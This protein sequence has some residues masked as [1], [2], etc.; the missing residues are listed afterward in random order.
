MYE[1]FFNEESV[2]WLSLIILNTSM[3]T[4]L[5]FLKPRNTAQYLILATLF[6]LDLFYISLFFQVMSI[7]NYLSDE[8][9]QKVNL[10]F[11]IIGS[12]FLTQFAYRFPEPNKK[13]ELERNI[14]LVFSILLTLLSISLSIKSISNP[15]HDYSD[16]YFIQLLFVLVL[17]LLFVLVLLRRGIRYLLEKNTKNAKS[18]FAF[19]I[20][21][22]FVIGTIGI[23]ILYNLGIIS[24]L[25]ETVADSI[26][27]LG[28]HLL[29]IITYINQ[30]KQPTS[31][32]IKI[33]GI[34]L[35]TVSFVLGNLGHLFLP[36]FK[37]SYKKELTIRSG[38]NISFFRNSKQSYDVSYSNLDWEEDLGEEILP[39]GKEMTSRIKLPFTFPFYQKSLNYFQ[40]YRT[41]LVSFDTNETIYGIR[42]FQYNPSICVVC[43]MSPVLDPQKGKIYLHSTRERVVVTWENLEYNSEL[44][45][46]E[47][48]FLQLT[49]TPNGDINLFYASIPRHQYFPK[50][51]WSTTF[52][53]IGLFPGNKSFDSTFGFLSKIPFSVSEE[54]AISEHFY[55]NAKAYIHE[56]ML[57]LVLTSIAV[58]FFIIL[59]FP[60]MF[61]ASLV[62]PL[63]DLI[64]GIKKIDRGQLD[65]YI[66]P[67]SNDEIGFLTESF[68]KM[69]NSIRIGDEM[70]EEYIEEIQKL[71]NAYQAFFPAEFLLQMSKRSILDIKLGDYK[72]K[73]MTI[74]FSDLR[75]YTTLSEDMSPRENFKFLNSYLKQVSPIIRQ[76]HGF[77]DKYIGDAI[78][79][80][81]PGRVEDA[82]EAA[83]DMQSK[84]K[85]INRARK[86]FHLAPIRAGVGIHTGHVIMGTIGETNR[87]EGTVVSDAV[88]ISSRLE[89][90][91][92]FYSTDI[93]ISMETFIEIEDQ[94]Q[95]FFRILDKVK[96]KGKARHITVIEIMNGLEPI[97]LHNLL[98]TKI[99]F[100]EGIGHYLERTF[101]KAIECFQKVLKV[102]PDDQASKI[103]IQRAEFYLKNGVPVDWNGVEILDHTFVD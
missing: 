100:E 97:K 87:M 56:R 43:F 37:E 71:N 67:R 72:E 33:V 57:P 82:I 32:M 55:W 96:V 103:Y 16:L 27:L 28:F 3:I 29:F 6:F 77:I 59:I 36:F 78:M 84:I 60:I 101:S 85:K 11:P 74:Y 23:E 58:S 8:I 92:K 38:T 95:F 54:I 68:N 21:F 12:I 89:N 44:G 90:L 14:T 76:K 66:E 88:N 52:D 70:K 15:Q 94:T 79:A 102:V 91:T 10:N 81:F 30:S 45:I 40:I 61:S 62:V 20:P 35:V 22:I 51:T 19:L 99:H 80:L 73:T 93:L 41:P 49:F 4:Y 18:L 9:H 26:G 64:S 75:S 98:S 13:E 63:R 69:V 50:S 53:V 5:S 1:I 2:S 24:E 34:T 65:I 17:I 42:T 39:S 7:N 46:S 25:T 83:I 86:L 48:M 31:F 47:Q